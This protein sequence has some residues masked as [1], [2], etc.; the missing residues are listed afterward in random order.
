MKALLSAALLMSSFLTPQTALAS[1]LYNENGGFGIYQPEGW[2]SRIEGRSTSLSGPS[3]D[4]AQSSIFLG[5]DWSAEADTLEHLKALV[6]EKTGDANPE[7]IGVSGLQGFRAGSAENGALY[8]LR[9]PQNFIVVEF[10]LRGSED[11]VREGKVM[12]GSIEIRTRPNE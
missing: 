5:S 4:S 2:S 1:W 3:T 8:L 9:I 6:I 12:L 10:E 7:A 11:Q